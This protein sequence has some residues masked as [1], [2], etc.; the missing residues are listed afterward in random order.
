MIDKLAIIGVGLIGGSAALALKEE[1][2]VKEVVGCGRGEANLI[3][4][5]SLGV[6]DHYTHD[7]G[8]AVKGA[9]MVLLSV[10]LG[11]MRDTLS[12]MRGQLVDHAV[13]TDAG[14]VKCSVVNDVKAVFGEIPGFFVPGHPIAG[15]ERS[16]AEAAFAEL[17]RNRRVILTPLQETDKDAL[18]R[19][20][21]MWQQCGADVVQMTVEHHDE[22]LAATSHL[23]HMLAFTLVDSLARMKENDEIFRFAAGGFRDFTRI[24]SSNPVMWR[25]ICI[26]NQG[27]LNE[28]LTRFAGELHELAALLQSGD[29]TGLLE[30]FQRAKKARD[31][32]V[33]GVNKS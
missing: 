10:P 11:A 7:V 29:E 9:D 28:M 31:R 33:D 8:A 5:Q 1:G 26:A 21:R 17:Y 12:G 24:A 16:G 13:V 25:D 4:A 18:L 6:I 15:T 30:I 22:V 19:V 2:V 20:E 27:Y 32:Y 14:S 23:P 3:K